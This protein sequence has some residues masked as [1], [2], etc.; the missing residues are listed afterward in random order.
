MTSITLFKYY[1]NGKIEAKK[2]YIDGLLNGK[3]TFWYKTGQK[4]GEGSY[5]NGKSDG[6][7]TWWNN[8]GQKFEEWNYKDGELINKTI[9]KYSYFTGRLKSK[10]I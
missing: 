4:Y 2:S 6:K 5:I 1:D 8:K 9:F 10:K 3:A 7:W